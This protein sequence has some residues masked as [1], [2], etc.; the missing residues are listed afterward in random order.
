MSNT[1]PNFKKTSILYLKF[2]FLSQVM[3]TLFASSNS[4]FI[5]RVLSNNFICEGVSLWFSFFFLVFFPLTAHPSLSRWRF[6]FRRW[7]CWWSFDE[8]RQRF[9]S[10][11]LLAISLWMWLLRIPKSNVSTV[12][13]KSVSKIRLVHHFL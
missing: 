5:V 1:L 8:A 11:G 7:W 4:S 2:S 10:V 12:C 3:A 9:K 13:L 6:R